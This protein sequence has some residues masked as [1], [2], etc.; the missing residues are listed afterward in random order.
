MGFIGGVHLLP[1]TGEWTYDTVPYVAAQ[2][3]FTN[4]QPASAAAANTYYAPGGSK[5]DYSY[6]IDQLQA[7]HPECQ[8]VSVVCAW[9]FNSENAASC[10]I[11]PSTIYLLGEVWEVVSGSSVASHWMVSLE[12]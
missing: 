6:A 1:A 4:G 5:T 7:A 11:Y 12:E 3:N 10:Q 9:F 8:T 2:H